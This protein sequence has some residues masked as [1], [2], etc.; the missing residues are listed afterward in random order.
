MRPW[1]TGKQT[2]GENDPCLRIFLS[3]DN[4]QDLPA[5]RTNVVSSKVNLD[6]ALV[7]RNQV[8]YSLRVLV[9]ELHIRKIDVLNP[10]ILVHRLAQD[11]ERR[12]A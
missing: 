8:G 9:V 12:T 11:A 7:L 2:G 5:L 3:H 6:D 4:K 1:M 10:R